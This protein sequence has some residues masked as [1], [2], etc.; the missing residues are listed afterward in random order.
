MRIVGV[1]FLLDTF[2][3]PERRGG[4]K[5]GAPAPGSEPRTGRA[6]AEHGENP[7]LAPDATLWCSF[8]VVFVFLFL[9]F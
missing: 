1:L 3:R 6:A 5:S 9:C 4:G 8:F 7:P 2:A